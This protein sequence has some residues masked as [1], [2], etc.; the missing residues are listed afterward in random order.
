MVVNPLPS[1]NAG[2]DQTVCTGASVTLNG[3]GATNYSWNNSITNGLSFVPSA[4]TTYTVTLTDSNGCVSTDDVNVILT[5]SCGD[6]FVPTAFSPND[7][8]INS[9]FRIKINANCVQTMQLQVFDRW[10]ELMFE[11]TN[12]SDAW[13]GKYKGI[14]QPMDAYAWT[15]DVEYFT[16]Q[17]F[18]KKGD[19]TLIR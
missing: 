3:S 15:L 10:G 7:D 9:A 2:V 8:A 19:V 1:V 12:P 16:G 5:I 17:S 4:T 11:T 14:P 6:L 13:D 18:R